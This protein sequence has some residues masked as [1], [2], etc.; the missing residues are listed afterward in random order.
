M[1]DFWKELGK[2]LSDITGEAET[3]EKPPPKVDQWAR[4][5]DSDLGKL[6]NTSDSF[7]RK[8]ENMMEKGERYFEQKQ[9]DI[10]RKF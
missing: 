8:F 10:D 1:P 2:F 4:E 3:N 9:N 6:D 5:L 7:W